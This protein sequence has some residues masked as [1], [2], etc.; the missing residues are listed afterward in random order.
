MNPQLTYS[1]PNY[2]KACGIADILMHT[3][4]TLFLPKN[5]NNY[6]T[7]YIAEGLL[8]RCHHTSSNHDK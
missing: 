5:K 1:A 6:L 7:D 3:L 4:E 2:Q 8:K